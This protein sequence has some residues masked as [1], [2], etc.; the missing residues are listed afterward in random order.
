MNER[1]QASLCKDARNLLRSHIPRSRVDALTKACLH[2]T[3]TELAEASKALSKHLA[4]TPSWN[5]VSLLGVDLTFTCPDD[6]RAVR[7]LI[8]F[9]SRYAQNVSDEMKLTQLAAAADRLSAKVRIDWS[10]REIDH[11]RYFIRKTIGTRPP[12][13]RNLRF[14][15]GNGA[16]AT[17]E[18][19]LQKIY[20]K[21]SY[22]KVDS[23]LGYL[24][25]GL[26]HLPNQPIHWLQRAVPT[27]KVV[28]VPKDAT[29][30]RVISEE[31]LTMQ[32]FQQGLMAWLYQRMARTRG[33]LFPLWDTAVSRQL[34]QLGSQAEY[35]GRRLQP[36]TIDLSDASDSVRLEHVRL[37]F[38]PEWADCLDAFRSEYAYFPELDREIELTTFAPMGAAT[39]YPV[40]SLVFAAVRYAS[41]RM[42]RQRSDSDLAA[43]VGDDIITPAYTY[44]CLIEL[45]QRGA[46]QPNVSKCCGPAVRFRESCGGDYLE[47]EDVTYVRPR[48]LPKWSTFAANPPTVELAAGLLTRGFRLTAQ[49]LA[50]STVGPVALGEGGGCAPAGLQWPKLGRV[51]YNR[52]LQRYEQ[53]G[54]V[55]SYVSSDRLGAV[56]S[57]EA[58]YTHLTSGWK[59]ETFFPC[60][61]QRPRAK[62]VYFP[63]S[64]DMHNRIS[65]EASG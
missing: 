54:V 25:E 65:G 26:L 50:D 44:D 14:R 7:Q 45:L 43:V 34:A 52:Y 51:R 36:C 2:A 64:P 18:K 33:R 15:H 20:F 23:Y 40:E 8:G 19:G 63:I 42:T 28:A 39:C 37:L 1:I 55:E 24:S 4:S 12:D 48:I 56:D 61:G 30:I 16:V 53:E 5:Q 46:F 60:R 10:L 31:P 17:G 6:V 21:E 47:G 41:Y 59:S 32:F 35:W 22:C 29:R 38:P 13:F 9:F 58:L 3:V 27:T 11:M 62:R 57:W 49:L